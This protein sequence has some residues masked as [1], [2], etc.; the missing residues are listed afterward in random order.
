[1]CD[2]YYCVTSISLFQSSSS[3]AGYSHPVWFHQRCP[4]SAELPEVGGYLAEETPLDLR[5]SR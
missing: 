4:L 5:Q 1:M 2:I 3:W